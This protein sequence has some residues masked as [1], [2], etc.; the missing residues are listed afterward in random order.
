LHPIH[1]LS[2]GSGGFILSLFLQVKSAIIIEN[3][4]PRSETLTARFAGN[5][6]RD[7]A[8]VLFWCIKSTDS[9]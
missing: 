6:K 9:G 5:L 1:H 8:E 7:I 3:V 2:D 4:M